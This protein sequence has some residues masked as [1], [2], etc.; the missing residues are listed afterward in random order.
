MGF[1]LRDVIG[2]IHCARLRLSAKLSNV[3]AHAGPDVRPAT[4]MLL[5]S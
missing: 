1:A 4:A 3:E 5:P 2:S